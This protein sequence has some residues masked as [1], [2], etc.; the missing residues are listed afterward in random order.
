MS[1]L[2]NAT[3]NVFLYR[4]DSSTAVTP[5]VPSLDPARYGYA[6]SAFPGGSDVKAALDELLRLSV[7][8]GF[9]MYTS[10]LEGPNFTFVVPDGVTEVLVLSIGQGGYCQSFN[11]K[12]TFTRQDMP[13][14]EGGLACSAY[15]SVT[16]GQ[17]VPVVVDRAGLAQ[18]VMV[19]F[20]S[21]ALPPGTNSFNGIRFT[22]EM[23]NKVFSLRAGSGGASAS[24]P[25]G[26]NGWQAKKGGGGGGFQ[27]S[28]S[29]PPELDRD[30]W[31][32]VALGT[33]SGEGSA[34]TAGENAFVT[35]SVLSAGSN[36]KGW[37]FPGV[38][39]NEGSAFTFI[40]RDG[41]THPL[42]FGGG[43]G[44]QSTPPPNS[45]GMNDGHGNQWFVGGTA[46]PGA[47]MIFW[48]PDIRPA[49]APS[50]TAPPETT[51]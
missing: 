5:L 24:L 9:Q 18:G 19:H 40:S 43:G 44:G 1:I 41:V 23:E 37:P 27:C 16:P 17:R 39:P 20:G 22:E 13:G 7:P 15:F 38:G 4:R 8:K 3:Q 29:V 50:S 51:A 46:S 12:Q 2:L 6:H 14:G 26:A 31:L 32:S 25:Y 48:G 28:D 36:G 30:N 33:V 11:V 10:Y 35:D 49:D 42:S 45:G 21:N 47:L 34:P